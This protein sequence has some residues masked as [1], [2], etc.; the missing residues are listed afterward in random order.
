MKL[1]YALSFEFILIGLLVVFLVIRKTTNSILRPAAITEEMA[2]TPYPTLPV[3]RELTAEEAVER[4]LY[5]DR[6]VA[7][8]KPWSQKTC[9]N[10]PERCTVELLPGEAI[11]FSADI[12]GSARIWVVT[13]T[14]VANASNLMM[15]MPEDELV[16]V[17]AYKISAQTGELMGMHTEIMEP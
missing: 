14:G 3:G 6:F 8:E 13:I 5:W 1:R 12:E 4:A 10:E 7:W 11:G 9:Q 2:L 17:V 15:H 16:K